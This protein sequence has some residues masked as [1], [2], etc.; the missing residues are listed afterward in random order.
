MYLANLHIDSWPS[1]SSTRWQP[2]SQDSHEIHLVLRVIIFS[3]KCPYSINLK[4]LG[5]DICKLSA[6]VHF[7]KNICS[8]N[9]VFQLG[10]VLVQYRL[11]GS[12]CLCAIVEILNEY[13]IT[14]LHPSGCRA[15]VAVGTSGP[16]WL[17]W[18]SSQALLSPMAP[19]SCYSTQQWPESQL[20][21]LADKAVLT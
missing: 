8:L 10:S 11:V 4:D 20:T 19:R 17:A 18:S 14:T 3:Q 1:D 15:S 16:P 9:C 6:A 12:L 2:F 5:V 7:V 13:Q 21:T